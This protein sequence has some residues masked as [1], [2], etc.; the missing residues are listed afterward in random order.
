MITIAIDPGLTSGL[1]VW[2]HS[3]NRLTLVAEVFGRRRLYEDV[4]GYLENVAGVEIVVEEYEITMRTGTLSKQYDALYI[5][6]A[7]ESMCQRH[8]APFFT[9]HRSA[10]TFGS[11][12]KLKHLGW[13]APSRGGHQNDAMRHLLRHLIVTK[14]DEGLLTKIKEML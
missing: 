6:G 9:Q 4:E 10:K 7:V 11:D 13:Y 8:K 3:V 12:A 1:V 5:I 2:E 14:R